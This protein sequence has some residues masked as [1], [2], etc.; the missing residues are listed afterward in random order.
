LLRTPRRCTGADREPQRG[1]SRR[2]RAASSPS[3]TRYG[4]HLRCPQGALSGCESPFPSRRDI[5]GR[6]K[7]VLPP[8]RPE[9]GV[10]TRT[11]SAVTAGMNTRSW[12]VP[13]VDAAGA[14]LGCLAGGARHHRPKQPRGP[15]DR[16][17]RGN[18]WSRCHI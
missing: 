8:D 16:A 17:S 4:D 7:S 3:P 5:P 18:D 10:R 11:S 13:I 14:P 9:T 6:P 2:G 12:H 1:T 15:H